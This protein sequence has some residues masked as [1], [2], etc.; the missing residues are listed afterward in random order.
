MHSCWSWC[1]LTTGEKLSFFINSGSRP[2]QQLITLLDTVSY[3][4]II[5]LRLATI[6][7]ICNTLQCH[8]NAV[9]FLPNSHNRHHIA[10]P[11]GWGM[12]RFF[13]NLKCNLNS[14]AV[15]PVAWIISSSIGLHYN[16]TGL[17][18]LL[19]GLFCWILLS[20]KYTFNKIYP[21]IH[22][23]NSWTHLFLPFSIWCLISN[24]TNWWCRSGSC[25]L[26]VHSHVQ[27]LK[28]MSI[29]SVL[30]N[31][32]MLTRMNLPYAYAIYVYAYE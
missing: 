21:M 14:A 26:S 12:G 15:I 28:I 6:F 8:Y 11:W 20:Y 19:L 2:Q 25:R 22:S 30:H 32:T 29:I 1:L 5:L 3:A 7:Y 13:V 16:S 10:R 4:E 9:S 24:A 18:F 27:H 17:Y 31:M 23:D